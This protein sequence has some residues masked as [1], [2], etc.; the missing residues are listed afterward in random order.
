MRLALVL[1][2][3]ALLSCPG[4][5]AEALLDEVGFGALDALSDEAG[6]DPREVAR[7][8]L[9][10][11]FA[12]DG[13]LPGRLLDGLV[14]ALREEWFAV[15]RLLAAPV[16]AAL[17]VRLMLAGEAGALPLACRLA[18]ALGLMRR[19]AEAAQIAE[20]AMAASARMARVA[21][22]VLA[23]ALALTGGQAASAQLTPLSA[24][25]VGGVQ[26]AL[27]GVGLPLCALAA[28]VAVA[29]NL[30]ERFRLDAL[31]SL[32]KRAAGALAGLTTA[33]FVG[34][35]AVQGR[36]AAAQD[37]LSARAVGSAL[38]RAVPIIGGALSD[39]SGALVG[40]ALGLR[41]AVGAAGLALALGVCL[42]PLL[43]L[44]ASM[45]SVKLAAAVIEPVADPGTSR[46]ASG[47]GDALQLL[48][49]LCVAGTMLT[50]LLAG[51]LLGQVG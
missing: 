20:G 40:S 28:A 21:S 25:C 16:L 46:I 17:V 51:S 38:K 10:G 42:K 26:K 32:I 41:N 15:L 2:A 34:L 36:L 50:A 14:S 9:A 23:A 6:I 37:T 44:A 1:L 47:I 11:D 31:F 45:L 49:T 30:S 18:A 33:G 48:L 29:G 39:A 8:V 43:A 35:I 12:P 19:F 4:A 13:E 27:A 22:P 5:R 3:L 7:R 24:L